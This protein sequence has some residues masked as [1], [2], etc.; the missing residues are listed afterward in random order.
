[1]QARLS[2]Q[3]ALLDQLNAMNQDLAQ[4]WQLIQ[5]AIHTACQAAQRSSENIA[6]MG[7][8]KRQPAESIR[9]LAH[10]GLVHLGENYLQEALDQQVQLADLP[11][12]WHF[13]GQLQSNKTTAIATHFD[14][15]HTVDRNKIAQRLNQHRPDHLPALQVCLQ[16]NIDQEPQKGGCL[17]EAL[18]TLAQTVTTLPRLR[19]RGLMCLPKASSD[20]T[21]AFARLAALQQDLAEHGI[22][23]DTLSMG[24]SA[25]FPQAIAQGATMIRV[26]SALFGP[27][28]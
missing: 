25:D 14:W 8:S 15:V 26:G 13:I 10:L 27:R 11:L 1:M 6:L 23:T 21:A 5:D 28:H 4:R 20:P 22:I 24:M 16:V 2:S 17:P 9:I 18:L 3:Q 7:V 19:L 12:T